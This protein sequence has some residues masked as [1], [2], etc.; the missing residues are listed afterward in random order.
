MPQPM[1]PPSSLDEDQAERKNPKRHDY[2][3]RRRQKAPPHRPAG[4][5]RFAHDAE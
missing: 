1:V 2:A 4:F 5:A 3:G